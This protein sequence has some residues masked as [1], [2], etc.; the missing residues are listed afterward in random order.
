MIK[1]AIVNTA[2]SLPSGGDEVNAVAAYWA[3]GGDLTSDQNLTPNTLIDPNSGTIDYTQASWSAGSWSTATDSLAASWS[4]AS[5][6][7]VSCSSDSSGD[8]SPTSASW[9]T[10][11][12]TTMWG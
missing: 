4:A 12:W 6:S 8:V 3:D 2:T 11:G 1:G 5:W 7:C 9:S 10:V